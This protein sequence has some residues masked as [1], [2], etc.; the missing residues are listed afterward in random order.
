MKN[1]VLCGM[2]GVGKTSVGRKIA[3][4]TRRCFYDTDDLIV[5]KHGKIGDI[6]EYYGENYFRNI[7]TQII[8]E[9]AQRQQLVISTGGGA[10]LRSE[11]VKILKDNGCILVH[12]SATVETIFNRVLPESGVRP[13][14]ANRSKESMRNRIN[15]LLNERAVIYEHVADYVVSTDGKSVEEVAK[16]IIKITDLK[17][18]D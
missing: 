13:L 16:E 14:L 10:V 8:S 6:F 1:I 15:T 18:L 11:N 9:I 4:L 17:E 5:N 3:E 7:E 12:L 2:M